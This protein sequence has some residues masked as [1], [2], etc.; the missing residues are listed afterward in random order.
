VAS[1]LPARFNRWRLAAIDVMSLVLRVLCVEVV[2]AV[3]R[4][5]VD[6]MTTSSTFSPPL[7]IPYGLW[8]GMTLLSLQLGLQALAHFTK[9]A[10]ERGAASRGPSRVAERD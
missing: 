4:A 3:S 8:P 6:K 7:T 5:W 2:D 9:R 10:N 1:I